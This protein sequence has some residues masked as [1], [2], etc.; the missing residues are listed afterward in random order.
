MNS[1]AI[2]LLSS[3]NLRYGLQKGNI[4]KSLYGDCA[5]LKKGGARDRTQNSSTRFNNH[6]KIITDT[7]E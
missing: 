3:L 6:K 4:I 7:N 1:T 5:K 2:G